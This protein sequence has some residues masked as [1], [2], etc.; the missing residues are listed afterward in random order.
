MRAMQTVIERLRNPTFF[1]FS[2]DI[3]FVRDNLP[4]GENIVF[5]DHN[6]TSN[7]C[8][9][10]RLM[11]ACNHNIIANSTFSWWGAWLNPNPAKVVC[12]PSS[13]HNINPDI[14]YP[15]LIPPDW[16]RIATEAR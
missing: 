16:L 14:S 2:D 9:D 6:D 12:A 3:D 8:E 5:V 10:F 7:A 11:S 13:W 4:K 1:V 15:D